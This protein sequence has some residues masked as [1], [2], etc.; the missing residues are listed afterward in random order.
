MHDAHERK[1]PSVLD[2]QAQ[3]AIASCDVPLAQ[4]VRSDRN[5]LHVS[6]Q[7]VPLIAPMISDSVLAVDPDEVIGSPEATALAA[8]E[9]EEISWRR[10]R[11]AWCCSGAESN[12]RAFSTAD[13]TL[14]GYADAAAA[15]RLLSVSLL[16]LAARQRAYS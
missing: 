5:E 10:S 12:P 7:L 3:L 16:E 8:L 2:E 6:V 11:S 13:A 15:V 1:S 9:A 14:A 4:M